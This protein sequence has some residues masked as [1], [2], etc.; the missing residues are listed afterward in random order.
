MIIMIDSVIINN[1]YRLLMRLFRI[2]L[3]LYQ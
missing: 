3:F 2:K 1:I